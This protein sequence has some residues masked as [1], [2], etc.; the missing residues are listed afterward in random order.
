[1]EIN[2][3]LPKLKELT[4]QF[5]KTIKQYKSLNNDE[6]NA[7]IDFIDKQVDE[8]VYKIFRLSE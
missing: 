6:S 5:H 4:D 2:D 8:L 3:K 7:R 1:M